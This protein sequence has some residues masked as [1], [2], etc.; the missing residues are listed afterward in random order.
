MGEM[1]LEDTDEHEQSRTCASTDQ[2]QRLC[3]TRRGCQG[4]D[5]RKPETQARVQHQR[6]QDHARGQTA[7]AAGGK[8]DVQCDPVSRGRDSVATMRTREHADGLDRDVRMEA[9]QHLLN[10]GGLDR[11][12]ASIGIAGHSGFE[13]S[14]FIS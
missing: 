2:R 6:L 13:P 10:I 11:S 12:H 5:R 1:A 8:A 3:G 4:Q 14:A 9:A 7:V